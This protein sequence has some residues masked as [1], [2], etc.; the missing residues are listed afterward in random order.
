MSRPI[1]QVHQLYRFYDQLGQLL[2]VG[3]SGHAVFRQHL[4]SGVP[5]KHEVAWVRIENHPNKATALAAERLAI[6]AE[7][8]AWNVA[9]FRPPETTQKY[10]LPEPVLGNLMDQTDL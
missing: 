2:Y 1:D 6:W 9:Q 7:K 5:W 4:N 8:P 10:R 3:V